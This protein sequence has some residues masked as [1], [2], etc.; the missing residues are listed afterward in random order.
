M[1]FARRTTEYTRLH[2]KDLEISAWML[3]NH[4]RLTQIP[5]GGKKWETVC[6]LQAGKKIHHCQV[7]IAVLFGEHFH[8]DNTGARIQWHLMLQWWW[9]LFIYIVSVFPRISVPNVLIFFSILSCR[10]ILMKPV[11]KVNFN[12]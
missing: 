8:R 11:S 4:L 10:S 1:K 2:G 3:Q 7:Y 5:I 9:F 6:V 12:C